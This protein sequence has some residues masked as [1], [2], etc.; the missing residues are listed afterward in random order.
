VKRNLPR[1]FDSLKTGSSWQFLPRWLN[2]GHY[3]LRAR[4]SRPTGE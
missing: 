2:R 4:F 3:F 1:V